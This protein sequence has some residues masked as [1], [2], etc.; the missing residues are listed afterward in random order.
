MK[1]QGVAAAVAE[2]LHLEHIA[3]GQKLGTARQVESFAMPLID[4]FRPG[5]DDAKPGGV[6][7][8]G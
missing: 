5:V 4:L 6:G 7:R 1:L 3:L 8:I 2:R